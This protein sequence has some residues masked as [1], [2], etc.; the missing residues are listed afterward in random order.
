MKQFKPAFPKDDQPFGIYIHIPFCLSRCVYC[1]FATTAHDP[2]QEEPYVNAVMREMKLWGSNGD[3]QAPFVTSHADTIYIGGGTP[4]IL[5]VGR[6]ILLIDGCKSYFRIAPDSEITVEINPATAGPDAFRK[7]RAAGIN[8]ASLGVQSF[9][10]EELQA[11]GRPHTASET[12]STFRELREAGFDNISVDLLAG[13]PGQSLDRL[14][15]TLEKVFELAPE[16]ISAYLLEVKPGARLERLLYRG[17]I[18]PIDEDLVADMYEEIVSLAQRAGYEQYEIS[19]FA[20]PG[21][22]SRHNLKYWT[23]RVFLGLGA[24]A[25]GMNGRVRYV[26]IEEPA[27]YVAAL[28]RATLP[29]ASLTELT[30]EARFKDALIMG[31]RLVEGLDLDILGERYQVDAKD[32]VMATIGDLAGEGLFTLDRDRLALTSRGRL[33]S[34]VIFARWV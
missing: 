11:M 18:P 1:G 3:L 16:H 15:V 29:R 13:F 24:G 9:H 19:N 31:L 4:S 21:K 32:F 28:N 6:L 8:R 5:Q 2:A 30:P 22:R 12:V 10:D 27:K 33:L 7:M 20:K 17:E 26:N 23:D 34:N 14:R 25:T